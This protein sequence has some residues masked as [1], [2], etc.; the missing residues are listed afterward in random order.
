MTLHFSTYDAAKS[1]SNAN[2]ID[3]E[4]FQGLDNK[5]RR[6]WIVRF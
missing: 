2:G 3:A 1:Y 4:I 6:G 5:G